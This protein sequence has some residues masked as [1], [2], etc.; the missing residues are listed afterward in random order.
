[1][2]KNYIDFSDEENDITFERARNYCLRFGKSKGVPLGKLIQK[3]E[4]RQYLRWCLEWKDLK[5]EPR[6]NIQCCL[7]AYAEM[8]AKVIGKTQT[9]PVN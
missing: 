4:G 7:D 6:A 2:E 5:E 9:K 8:K 1:M 3:S